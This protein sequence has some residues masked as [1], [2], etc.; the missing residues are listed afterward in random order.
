MALG[1]IRNIYNPQD[2]VD[3]AISHVKESISSV[4]GRIQDVWEE[5]RQ[6]PPL[7][8]P[9][10]SEYNQY[11]QNQSGNDLRA[12]FNRGLEKAFDTISP[13]GLAGITKNMVRGIEKGTWDKAFEGP[14]E[15]GAHM[16]A[17]RKIGKGF[18]SKYKDKG[19]LRVIKDLEYNPLETVDTGAY[20]NPYTTF[21]ALEQKGMDQL[22]TKQQARL[23]QIVKDWKK[24]KKWISSPEE[25]AERTIRHNKRFQQ[26]LKDSG[27]DSLSY[28]A[29][30]GEKLD[31]GGDW[32]SIVLFDNP[33][34][35]KSGSKGGIKDPPSAEDTEAVFNKSPHGRK[36]GVVWMTP[37]EYIK[38]AAKGFNTLDRAAY[39]ENLKYVDNPY[40]PPEMTAK[41][42]E[43]SRKGNTANE[44]E[45][46]MEEGDK[47]P[48]GVLDYSGGN[49]YPF[50]QEGL[51]RAVAAKQRGDKY[52]PVTIIGTPPKRERFPKKKRNK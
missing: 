28:K 12:L 47:F 20:W 15:M 42:L 2:I 19:E 17:N 40:I 49:D 31:P 7:R 50:S 21:K 1:D 27:Y 32:E 4:P 10:D 14:Y 8:L 43:I 16:T 46:A 48:M 9:T 6:S 30:E 41:D 18:A 29:V 5:H 39:K 26:V 33:M 44:Y 13:L 38:K 35:S 51:H 34:A 23:R 37:D 24:D 52:I 3:P 11:K 25:E 36:E 22:P 45:L